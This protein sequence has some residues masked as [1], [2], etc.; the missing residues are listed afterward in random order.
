MVGL[1]A[2]LGHQEKHQDTT[3][4]V[5]PSED[6]SLLAEDDSQAL[7]AVLEAAASWDLEGQ[8]QGLHPAWP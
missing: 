8:G 1:R 4:E 6:H 3:V 2:V 7:E 5:L